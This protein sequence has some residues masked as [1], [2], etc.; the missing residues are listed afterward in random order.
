MKKFSRNYGNEGFDDIS[1]KEIC[2]T[3]N[4]NIKFANSRF[5]VNWVEEILGFKPKI[6]FDIGVWDCG[7][8]IR[9]KIRY[10]EAKVYSFEADPDRSKIIK[11]YISNFEIDFN[12]FAISDVD[13]FID[14]YQALPSP[15]NGHV[16][17]SHGS[18][19]K[20]TDYYKSILSFVKQSD[21]S[22]KVKSKRLE[23][24]CL[25]NNIEDI[26]LVHLDVEGAESNVLRG[27][28]KI[29]PKIIYL[30]TV[31]T[32][33]GQFGWHGCVSDKEIDNILGK[34]GYTMALDL[35][36]DKLFVRN[37]ILNGS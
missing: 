33:E 16:F 10:P 15:F 9:L 18:M 26:D 11:E 2:K 36:S 32:K 7:D 1:L 27:M 34:M 24:F 14:F 19:F 31:Y 29:K 22:I 25:E 13:G 28:G 17:T 35:T 4:L 6:I 37:D 23:T 12:D 30:E 20:H 5:N 21:S 3:K 8:S